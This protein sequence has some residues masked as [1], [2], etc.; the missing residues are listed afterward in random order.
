MSNFQQQKKK[1]NKK[2]LQG[3]LQGKKNCTLKRKK[4]SIRIELKHTM[5][6]GILSL[7]IF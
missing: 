7:W 1:K 6:A 4:T 5:D 2:K 3:I